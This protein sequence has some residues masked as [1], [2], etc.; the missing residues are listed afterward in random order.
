MNWFTPRALKAGLAALAGVALLYVVGYVGFWQWGVCRVEVPPG[1]SLLLNYR[2]PWPFGTMP[3]APDGSL[4]QTDAAGRPLQVGILEVMP[5]PGRHFYSPLE[6]KAELVKDQVI[7]PGKIGVLVAKFGKPLPQG[8]YLVDGE[9]YR[10]IHRRV[11]TPGRYRVNTYGYDV[12]VVDVD[13]CVE[14][15]TRAKRTEEDP[16]LIPPGYVGVVTNRT[17][18]PLTGQ[19]QGI[20]P[21]VLQPGIYFLNPAEKRVDIVGIGYS[22]TTLAVEADPRAGRESP[23]AVADPR[24]DRL[25]KTSAR[26]PVYVAGKGIEFPSNDGFLI[27]LDFT[28]IWGITPK[29]APDVVRKFGTLDDVEE[30]VVLPQIGS[31]C[32]LHG[33]KQGAVDL[34]VGDSREVFQDETAEELQKVLESK[35]LSLL[36]GLTR[37]I[38]VP[39][40]V[41]EP[42]QRAKIA[43]ELTKTREQEQLTAKAQADLTEAKAKVTLEERRTKAETEKRVAAVTAEGEKQAKE[44]EAET[45][46]LKAEIDAKTAAIEAQSTKVLGEA[47]AK[48]VELR[49]QAEADRFRQYVQTLG[50]AEAYNKYVFAEG[51]SENLRLGVF[52]A[53]PGTFWTDLK[54]FEQALLGKVASE[55]AALKPPVMLPASDVRGSGG[56][57]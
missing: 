22:E 19:S 8:T 18:N 53:G 6:Y 9:G 35:N 7:P 50:G 5:G 24:G 46:R 52:Y 21:D 40:Q 57:R 30:K 56:R 2:G 29:Q 41:R 26:D 39:S 54:G 55:S 42:I 45:E 27:H 16:M 36:F 17:E 47:D 14:P 44:I 23:G 38:F 37:H 13:S 12:N 4:V 15:K 43:D 32:R 11:L 28:A 10:G 49:R 51:L 3:Q 1:Y 25:G 20:Q 31:I 33:S 48:K 34:L